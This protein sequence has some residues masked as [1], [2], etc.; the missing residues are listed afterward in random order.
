MLT[1]LPLEKTWRFVRRIDEA[2]DDQSIE[3][4][5]LD[6]TRPLGIV[7]IGGGVVPSLKAPAQEIR[8]RTLFQRFPDGWAERY[9]RCRYIYR[10]PI[11]ER[12]QVDRAPFT[13]KD[14]YSSSAH[15]DNVT[16]IEGEAKEF[17]LRGGFV[18]PIA[19]LDGAL[20]AISF[21]GAD[22]EFSPDDR[23]VLGFVANYAIGA[24]L[25]RRCSSR[26]ARNLLSPREHDC[27]LW[28]AEGKTDWEIATILGISKPTVTKHIL[29]AREKLGAVTKTHAI[30]RA[31]RQGII[32]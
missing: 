4:A 6:V 31:L 8:N 3:R 24:V 22:K 13:W 15:A 12:L 14:A 10:D 17:G 27:L 2:A 11:V 30:V 19:L 23:S 28:A 5:L 25:Q 1:S 9:N 16:L 32:R 29:S 26:R 7:L 21:G 18:V 20:A